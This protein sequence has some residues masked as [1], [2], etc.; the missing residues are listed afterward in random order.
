MAVGGKRDG[1]SAGNRKSEQHEWHESTVL[2][3]A[4]TPGRLPRVAELTWAS[5][6]RAGRHAVGAAGR[7][8][9]RVLGTAESNDYSSRCAL[10]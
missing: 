4:R 8:R 2:T 1:L 9:Q 5:V 7:R 10:G 6:N 3:V